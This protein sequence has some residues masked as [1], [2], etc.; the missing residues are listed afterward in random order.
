MIEKL[1]DYLIKRRQEKLRIPINSKD[2]HKQNEY[3]RVLNT[4]RTNKIMVE[5]RDDGI[6]I[7]MAGREERGECFS[8]EWAKVKSFDQF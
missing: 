1:T 2:N 4:L 7:R 8:Y 3:K 5:T 6:Y